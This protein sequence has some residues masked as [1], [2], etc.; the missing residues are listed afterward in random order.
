VKGEN[1]ATDF[2]S[3][4]LIHIQLDETVKMIDV[5]Q[6]FVDA[7]IYPAHP[8][9]PRRLGEPYGI[10]CF[11]SGRTKELVLK[12][13]KTA[14]IRHSDLRK[15]VL[16]ALPSQRNEVDWVMDNLP[17]IH[18][19]V[20]AR[21]LESLQF[22][23]KMFTVIL[24]DSFEDTQKDVP[25]LL[26]E[27]DS[28]LSLQGY[29]EVGLQFSI[30]YSGIGYDIIKAL[31]FGDYEIEPQRS[32]V[33][34]VAY[35]I[36]KKKQIIP[37]RKSTSSANKG[38]VALAKGL[39]VQNQVTQQYQ[40]THPWTVV[41]TQ[42]GKADIITYGSNGKVIEVVA[43]KSFSLEITL[44]RGCRN[45]KGHKYVASFT[46]SRDAKAEVEVA[47][48]RGLSQIRLIVV[49]LL[50]STKVFDDTVGFDERITL[51]QR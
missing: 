22:L 23:P 14:N 39:S 12:I 35:R 36:Y 18:A 3:I 7:L 10:V 15:I 24:T 46:A 11:D 13:V 44:G 42:R 40:K 45:E 27:I 38:R 2:L 31:R 48:K 43:I 37:A 47:K 4:V 6:T 51:R 28:A 1:N 30:K 50:T 17:I 9:D 21:Y 34:C 8:D 49:N 41:S 32:V 33:N 20:I 5:N 25:Q 16:W 19:E 26:R 29:D